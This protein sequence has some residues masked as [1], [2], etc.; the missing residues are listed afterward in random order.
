[1]I[2]TSSKLNFTLDHKTAGVYTCQ[3][4][5]EGFPPK[6]SISR[7][8]VRGPPRLEKKTPLVAASLGD[9]FELFCEFTSVPFAQRTYWNLNGKQSKRTQ[10]VIESQDGSRIKTSI[11][12]YN[13]NSEDFGKYSCHIEN[14][15]EHISEDIAVLQIGN[16]IIIKYIF[17]PKFDNFRVGANIDGYSCNNQRLLD[18]G[19]CYDSCNDLQKVQIFILSSQTS[20]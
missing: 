19:S 7:V 15:F 4:S 13:A 17:V 18:D 8:H 10:K 1:M 12:I 16:F 2:S 14:E 20:S 5:V 11:I 6:L 3:A 9:S